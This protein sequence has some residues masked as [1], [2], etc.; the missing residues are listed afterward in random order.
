MPLER[1][2]FRAAHGQVLAGA[3]RRDAA[4][5]ELRAARAG[6]EVV[7]A[8]PYRERVDQALR[9][10][11]QRIPGQSPARGLT[12]TEAVVARLVASGLS[13]K[14]VAQRLVMSAK[15]VEYHLGNVYAKVGVHSRG[16]L[17]AVIKT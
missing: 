5:A 6:L 11:G 14:Q 16:Q 12:A 3:G 9:R 15:G 7:G 2:R 4:V 13:N 8:A 1:A 17:A 10:L